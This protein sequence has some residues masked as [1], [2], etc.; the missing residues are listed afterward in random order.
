[1]EKR[2]SFNNRKRFKGIP[3]EKN[4]ILTEIKLDV[5][6]FWKKEFAEKRSSRGRNI[7]NKIY[8]L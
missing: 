7:R 5:Q 4:N 8:H 1:M 6:Y 3:N 2:Q